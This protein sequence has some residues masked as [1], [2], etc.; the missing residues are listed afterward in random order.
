[1]ATE[2]LPAPGDA[3]E[4][5]AAKIPKA[6]ELIGLL[7]ADV[8]EH[9]R[10]RDVRRS[11]TGHEVVVLEVHPDVPQRPIH[12][13]RVVER[14]AV[15]F[16]ANDHMAPEALAL[17]AD[18]PHHVSHLNVRSFDRPASLCLFEEPYEEQK[19]HWTAAGFVRQLHHWL[20]RTA[21]G[22][23][24]ELDQPLEQLFFLVDQLQH[25]VL[26]AR[27]FEPDA[28]DA[29]Q[30]LTVSA[31]PRADGK[32]P[33]LIA[34]PHEPGGPGPPGLRFVGIVVDTEP[35]THGVIRWQP[36]NLAQL[37]E[38]LSQVGV[39]LMG[40]LKENL[41]AWAHDEEELLDARPLIIVRLPKRR[42]DADAPEDVEVWAFVAAQTVRELGERLGFTATAGGYT[43]LL[44]GPTEAEQRPEDIELYLL[45]PTPALTRDRAARLN[46]FNASD[47]VQ[48]VA[49][50]AGALGSQVLLHLARAGYGI[51]TVIDEDVLLPHNL[52]RH[53]LDAFPLGCDKAWAVAHVANSLT[54]DDSVTPIV[55]DVLTDPPPDEVEAA[56]ETADVIV[57]FSASVSVA[58]RLALAVAG[59]ARRISL[60]LN[61]DGTDL[62]L[63]AEDEDRTYRLDQ[64]EMQYYGAV[65][66]REQLAG[67][68]LP[69]GTRIRYA[70]SCRD[71]TSTVP[72][73]AVAVLS[74]VAAR[75]LRQAVEDSGSRI[76]I[77]QTGQ[78]LSVTTLSIPPRT[79]SISESEDWTLHIHD[80]LRERLAELRASVLPNETGGV[81]LGCR[82]HKRRHLH[83]VATI[84]SPPDSDEWPTAY[85]RGCEGLE[86][87][88]NAIENR[89][90]G[91]LGYVGEWHSHP[92]GAECSPSRDDRAFLAWL[93]GHMF[94]D[95]Y[96]AL[97]GIVCE[98]G[99]INWQLG[100]V[101]SIADLQTDFE[102]EAAG[103]S[104]DPEG[105]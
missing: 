48:I 105:G 99:E 78:D 90:G 32:R 89:T 63:L 96:P 28:A 10:L 33:T 77:W 23:L 4:P 88:V 1:M 49:V 45:N 27:L 92:D 80:Q 66:E 93:T 98:A 42:T 86:A 17:R 52:A 36:T 8:L 79:V 91:W 18:F 50:G 102:S 97:M 24:H 47:D 62:V 72:Q 75:A 7:S 87:Q 15:V 20:S 67:H 55:A 56:L 16:G 31:V 22:E 38:R 3:I 39:D 9:V 58:R 71:V 11:A 100:S 82:D 73:D 6:R 53:A 70:H 61:P 2:Y 51:W 76:R 60:F 84:P 54:E 12:D 14:I 74:G 40:L 81:L 29:P 21:R 57:D 35:E 5:D 37:H 44:I 94:R 101:E 30:R 41:S 83:V 85:I 13:I 19:L 43:A 95:G 46:N 59:D 26:P 69:H 68:L 103:V 104:H 34:V 65:A 64:L 25:V